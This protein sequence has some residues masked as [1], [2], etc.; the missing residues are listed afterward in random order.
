MLAVSYEV[1]NQSSL[2]VSYVNISFEQHI[3]WSAH[4]QP[5]SSSTII[6]TTREAGVARGTGFGF[7][8]SQIFPEVDGNVS[9]LDQKKAR[10]ITI[11]VPDLTCFTTVSPIINVSYVVNV[12]AST[13]RTHEPTISLPIYAFR[14]GPRAAP[15]EPLKV[16]GNAPDVLI[17]TVVGTEYAP[18]PD[19]L[20]EV[21]EQPIEA[22]LV[23]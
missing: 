21:I 2:D 3:S 9:Y 14:S 15:S 12:K 1:D 16:N 20:V 18:N 13:T 10:Y 23:T 17:A 22:I 6:G 5:S 4:G 11:Q 19:Y 7:N 8:K